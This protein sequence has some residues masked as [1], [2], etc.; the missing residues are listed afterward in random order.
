MFVGLEAPR[1]AK[2]IIVVAI[3]LIAGTAISAM[4]FGVARLAGR[5]DQPHST[6]VEI[7]APDQHPAKAPEKTQAGRAPVPGKAISREELH[8]RVQL[9]LCLIRLEE[10]RDKRP[11]IPARPMDA[12]EILE[13]TEL[14]RWWD[15]KEDEVRQ[16]CLRLKMMAER[17]E[18]RHGDKQAH[19]Y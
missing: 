4:I 13:R 7:S 18:G 16:E 11:R 12:D 2:T 10:L 3:L 14:D 15:R 19:S 17:A 8:L 1:G 9:D 5:K 6:I